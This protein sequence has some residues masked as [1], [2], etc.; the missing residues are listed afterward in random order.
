M[1]SVAKHVFST[2]ME[3]GVSLL[4]QPGTDG[5]YDDPYQIRQRA[6]S[7]AA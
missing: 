4:T 5:N 7:N 6:R 2:N 3:G 1:S